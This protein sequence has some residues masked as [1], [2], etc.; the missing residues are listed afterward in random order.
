MNKK[1]IEDMQSLLSRFSLTVNDKDLVTTSAAANGVEVEV[2]GLKLKLPRD[3]NMGVPL[4]DNETWFTPY[5]DTID[6]VNGPAVEAM[7]TMS[8]LIVNEAMLNIFHYFLLHR[9]SLS[10]SLTAS[11][12]EKLLFDNSNIKFTKKTKDLIPTIMDADMG[13]ITPFN[14]RLRKDY[15]YGPAKVYKRASIYYTALDAKVGEE[16]L[17]KLNLT[18]ADLT[19]A[20]RIIAAI[21]KLLKLD[22]DSQIIAYTDALDAPSLMVLVLTHET[23]IYEIKK[24]GEGLP[25]FEFPAL[26]K[27]C[28]S[29]FDI[30]EFKT[31]V[32]S[33]A[34]KMATLSRK[35][36]GTVSLVDKVQNSLMNINT[37]KSATISSSRVQQDIP[38]YSRSH[39]PQPQHQRYVKSNN[40][41]RDIKPNEK[42]LSIIQAAALEQYGG[43]NE[44]DTGYTP[45]YVNSNE[46]RW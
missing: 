18:K 13:G 36:S 33:H 21:P 29:P 12:I 44:I 31:N 32:K 35:I 43:R 39:E 4:A 10:D 14:Y 22:D 19:I 37:G 42:P 38:E 16:A 7:L 30:D 45:R 9:D 26:V 23:L 40:L 11:K 20:K 28:L 1:M 3:N 15:S 46:R 2:D 34:I 41:S 17:N 24:L 27:N 5:V 8:K 25:G 6:T